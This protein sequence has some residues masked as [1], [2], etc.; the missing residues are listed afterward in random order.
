MYT[1]MWRKEQKQS[2]TR[3]DVRVEQ[4][5]GQA[6][7]EQDYR[8]HWTSTHGGTG[9]TYE[10]YGPAYCYGA[11]LCRGKHT[12]WARS[13]SEARRSWEEKYSRNVGE[14]E[15]RSALLLDR[16]KQELRQLS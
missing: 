5:S 13:E 4:L 12:D 8:S 15:R 10:Q 11:Q 16:T 2:E 1:R 6:D 3:S 7:D 14:D 9:L